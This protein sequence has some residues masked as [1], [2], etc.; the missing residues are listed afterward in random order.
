MTSS[1]V[2]AGSANPLDSRLGR[3]AAADVS[4]W[5]GGWRLA[6]GTSPGPLPVAAFLAAG[7]VIGPHG[8]ALLS[9]SMAL[10]LEPFAAVVLAAVG[11]LVGLDVQWQRGAERRL[12]AAGS[13]E[14]SCTALA[15]AAGLFVAFDVTDV[16]GPARW[17]LP[18]LIGIAGAPSAIVLQR[19][20][21][22][23]ESR[24]ARAGDLDDVLPI[25]VGGL[26]LAGVAAGTLAGAAWLTLATIA[27]AAAVG[28][29]GWLLAAHTE[30]ESERRVFSV[31][32]ILVLG[33]AAVYLRTSAVFAGLVVGA[34]W[35]GAGSRDRERL[36][37]DLRS[38]QHPLLVALLLLAGARVTL[39][40]DLWWFVAIFVACRMVGKYAGVWIAGLAVAEL[41]PRAGSRL[42]S[43]GVV[44]VA[45]A[46]DAVVGSGGHDRAAS[47]FG[48]V[49][50]G[51]IAADVMA[52][53]VH[54]EG[55]T[56]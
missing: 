13:L 10:T 12:L 36:A 25:V 34:L 19:R 39:S 35:N 30:S 47:A 7:I 5:G 28:A 54:R 41:T 3:V 16:P 33:G 44:G 20:A 23:A 50:A 32:I 31:G 4:R 29:A 45:L 18:L 27:S 8:L 9:S 53:A 1:T 51:A 49:I 52:L 40:P 6:L 2:T 14:A 42:L 55:P 22:H 48:I 56:R 46:L 24:A 21:R 37:R 26:L 43:F 17:M 11:L 38:L 15:I